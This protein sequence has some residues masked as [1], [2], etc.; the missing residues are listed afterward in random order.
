MKVCGFRLSGISYSYKKVFVVI[1][2][3]VFLKQ[4]ELSFNK[5]TLNSVKHSKSVKS[6]E[7][8]RSVRVYQNVT[9]INMLETFYSSHLQPFTKK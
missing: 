7:I 2:E 1:R 4:I 3:K 6:S 8:R 5:E 9:N